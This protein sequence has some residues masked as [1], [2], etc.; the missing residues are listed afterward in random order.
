MHSGNCHPGGQNENQQHDQLDHPSVREGTVGAGL[1][2]RFLDLGKLP[3]LILHKLAVHDGRRPIVRCGDFQLTRKSL[4]CSTLFTLAG[5]VAKCIDGGNT[6]RWAFSHTRIG[7]KTQDGAKP[8]GSERPL[9]ENMPA[10]EPFRP[11]DRF[12]RIGYVT[13]ACEGITN[14][15]GTTG[16]RKAENGA[17]R[18]SPMVV[19]AVTGAE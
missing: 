17:F 8:G 15:P 5:I 16:C 13:T 12:E 11:Q 14:R 7:E 18:T 2:A 19:I 3:H 6:E 10:P 9:G 4:R 1:T